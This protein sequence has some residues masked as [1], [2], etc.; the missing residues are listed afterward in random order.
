[1]RSVWTSAGR[2]GLSLLVGEVPVLGDV[3][4][5]KANCFK[6]GYVMQLRTL[7]LWRK[8]EKRENPDMMAG[9][10]GRKFDPLKAAASLARL[11][12]AS[13]KNSSEKESSRYKVDWSEAYGGGHGKSSS[14]SASGGIRR[15]PKAK[16]RR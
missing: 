7:E 13:T 16:R 12:K 1:M 8:W 9:Y 11:G 2:F 5:S 6:I 14:S 3:A 10:S 15:P 4:V